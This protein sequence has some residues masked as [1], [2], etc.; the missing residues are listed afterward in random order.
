MRELGP[1]E[2][3]VHERLDVPAGRHR[4]RRRRHLHLHPRA[5][6]SRRA[7]RSHVARDRRDL[8]QLHRRAPLDPLVG[9]Q[10]Q[11]DRAHR[12]AQSEARDRGA[13][14][15]ARSRSTARPSPSRSARRSSSTAGRS[16]RRAIRSSPPSSRSRRRASATTAR[17]C[18]A[19]KLWA[20]MEAEAFVTRD[21]ERLIEVGLAQISPDS[22][23]ARA[24]S[25]TFGT[26]AS[27]IRTG[28]TTRERDR[29]ALRLRQISRQLPR[30]SQPCAHDHGAA[31][32][33]RRL[34]AGADDRL[35]LRLGHRLQ[36]RQRRLPAWASMLGPR[37]DRRRARMA[38]AARR[39]HADLVRRR[40]RCD[41]RRGARQ[42]CGSSTSDASSRARRRSPPPKDGRA[43]SFLA[44]RQRAGICSVEGARADVGSRT[45][46]FEAGR[47]LELRF[48]GLGAEPVRVMTPTFT[49]PDVTRMRTYEL[50]ATPLVY[51]GQTVRAR[52]IADSQNARRRRGQPARPCLRRRRRARSARESEAIVLAPGEESVLDWRLPDTDG[53]PIQSLGVAARSPGGAQDGAIVLDWLRWDG[54]P[55]VRL[56]R[57]REPSDFWRRAW[58]NAVD[59]FSTTLP[60]GLPDFAGPRRRHDHPWR[61]AM[62]RL[63]GRDGAHSSSRRTCGRG[64][65]RAGIAAL[66]RASCLSGRTSCVW[67]APAT[68]RSTCSPRAPFAWSFEKP[69]R[70]VVEAVGRTIE[71]ARRRRQAFRARRR[72]GRAR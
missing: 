27:A 32:C 55:D 49:P 53:Q 70:F 11:F 9:R 48:D 57:P 52:V 63:P 19:A 45:S 42:R 41:Q 72:R 59:N 37:R 29:G 65:S 8:A 33:S 23:I 69:Y 21:V 35:H 6:R 20:A 66:L 36:R 5:R 64:R 43:V 71:V 68:A 28:A 18:D 56:R 15:A 12:L 24:R 39:P 50:M 30:R 4:R 22:P 47:A 1:I 14:A 34:L 7:R 58:V 16:S 62:A 13:G 67:F 51:P 61:P 54:S 10:R 17:R 60:A 3:Y 26:G 2:D 44:A 31:L 40:R 25:P 38:R 46:P